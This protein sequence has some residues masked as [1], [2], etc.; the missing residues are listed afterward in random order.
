MTPLKT[1]AKVG[2]D[3][4]LT[5]RYP[6]PQTEANAEVLVTIEPAPIP[7]NPDWAAFIN[8][9]AGSIEDESFERQDQGAAEVR[10]ALE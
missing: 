5:L 10:G 6:L 9:T 4:V 3:G 1:I 7:R 2:A 8:T